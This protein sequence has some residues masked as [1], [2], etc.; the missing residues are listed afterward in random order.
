M[1]TGEKNNR[2]NQDR[3]EAKEYFWTGQIASHLNLSALNT[4]NEELRPDFRGKPNGNEVGQIVAES[5][6]VA[7]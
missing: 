3:S 5:W 7:F 4:L 1:T 6:E 2:Q